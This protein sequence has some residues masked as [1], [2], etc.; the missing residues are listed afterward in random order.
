V[1][2]DVGVLVFIR[3]EQEA[4]GEAAWVAVGVCVGDVLGVGC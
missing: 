4:Y 1:R 3:R 2:D